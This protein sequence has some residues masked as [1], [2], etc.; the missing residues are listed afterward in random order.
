MEIRNRVVAS[1]AAFIF[2]LSSPSPAASAAGPAQKAAS[3]LMVADFNSGTKPNNLGGDFGAWIKD[4]N[5][6]MQGCIESFDRANRFGSSGFALRLIYSVDSK[7]PAFGGLWM[8]LQNLDASKFDSLA[9]RVKGDPRMG[10]TT[11][12]KVELKD[13]MDQSSH[14]Y[15]HGVTDQWQDL[16]I[17]LKDFEG[18][19]N[20][21]SLKE[22]VIV[23]EDTSA[24]SKKGVIYIDDVRFKRSAS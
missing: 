18:I 22:F 12:F 6:P 7:N 19:A 21:R 14:F 2:C 11:I 15:V 10:F 17:P 8:R 16:V 13:S 9:F 1:I 20:L 3:D 23:F 24:T 5:D 4:P